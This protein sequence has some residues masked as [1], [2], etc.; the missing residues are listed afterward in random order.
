MTQTEE[1]LK[2][3]DYYHSFEGDKFGNSCDH[4]EN[5]LKNILTT[6]LSQRP[7]FINNLNAKKQIR[8]YDE[9]R[10]HDIVQKSVSILQVVFIV[11]FFQIRSY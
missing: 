7:G 1:S 10:E 9:L 3:K 11:F 5:K 4:K 2:K 8:L 6:E